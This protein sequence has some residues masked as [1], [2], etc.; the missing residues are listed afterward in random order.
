MNMIITSQCEKCKFG[1]VDETD[2]ARVIVYCSSK[3]KTYY[4]GQ[5]IPCDNYTKK[6]DGEEYD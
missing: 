5:C 6:E 2:K 4:Y 3:D 1:T